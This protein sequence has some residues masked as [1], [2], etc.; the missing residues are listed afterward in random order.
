MIV[1][2]PAGLIT[3]AFAPNR[4][5]RFP[6]CRVE[7]FKETAHNAARRVGFSSPQGVCRRVLCAR[8]NTCRVRFHKNRNITLQTYNCYEAVPS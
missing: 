3:G 8:D 1:N 2:R 7:T 6:P 5:A 4:G